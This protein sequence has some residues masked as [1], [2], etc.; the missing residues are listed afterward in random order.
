M[1]PDIDFW[2]VIINSSLRKTPDE[3][4][5]NAG[6]TISCWLMSQSQ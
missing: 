3:S 5:F 2:G 4:P 1:I 6:K